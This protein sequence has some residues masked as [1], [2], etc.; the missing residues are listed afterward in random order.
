MTFFLAYIF[1][2]LVF[3]RPQDWLVPALYGWPILDAIFVVA[4]FALLI[5]VD[6]R[7][8]VIP[9]RS[10]QVYSLVG[11]FVAAILSHVAHTYLGGIFAT[12]PEVF[13]ICIFTLLFLCV[14]DTPNRLRAVAVAIVGLTIVMAVH[15]HLQAE[16]GWGFKGYPPL[17]IPPMLGKPAHTRTYFFGIFGDPNDLA[18]ML[19][20]AIPFAFVLF[21]RSPLLNLAIGGAVAWY[22]YG[23]LRTTHSR[24]GMVALVTVGATIPIVGWLRRGMPAW[25]GVLGIAALM[26]CPFAGGF[27]DASAQDRVV[28]WGL[29][30]EQFKSNL[31]FGIGYGMFWQVAKDM[32][33]HNAFVHCY[34]EIGLLGYWF[35]S[36]LAYVG[37]VGAWRAMRALADIQDEGAQYVRRFAGMA[38]CATLGYMA[39]AYFLSRAFLYPGFFLFAVLAAIPRIAEQYLPDDHPPLVA[40]KPDVLKRGSLV[41]LGSVIYIYFSI[42]FLNKA[43]YG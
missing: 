37:V 23:A 1:M 7:K 21:R 42:R 8:V 26:A 20:T 39:S 3:W 11:V 40:F 19:A 43:I 33:A 13:K 35:W 4:L 32:A 17:F 36:S 28:F 15:A 25:L 24:G 9:R 27:L 16:R 10:P 34:T 22:L 14:T 2:V 29:A 41:A 5:E 30:N 31:L 6:Q 12:A 38:I 18:Q